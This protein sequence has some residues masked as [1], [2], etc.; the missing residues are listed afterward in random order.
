[1]ASGEADGVIV[2]GWR[3]EMGWKV[4]KHVLCVGSCVSAL[5]SWKVEVLWLV[6]KWR[7]Q[8]HCA[9][10]LNLHVMSLYCCLD[11]HINFVDLEERP[12]THLPL[13]P[14]LLICPV[15]KSLRR[16]WVFNGIQALGGLQRKKTVSHS[17]C[18]CFTFC[19]W[20]SWIQVCSSADAET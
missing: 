8:S 15:L 10:A 13:L 2:A 7:C 11:D 6:G 18:D 17:S 19:C 9:L 14:D 1:M 4:R 5:Q 16:L 3:A 12:F 20:L